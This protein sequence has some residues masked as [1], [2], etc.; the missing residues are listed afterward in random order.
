[1]GTE[2]IAAVA[3]QIPNPQATLPEALSLLWQGMLGIFLVA[4]V[5]M[6]C[7]AIMGALTKKKKKAGGELS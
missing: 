2:I 4:A 6:A 5:M 7:A 1:M 3:E